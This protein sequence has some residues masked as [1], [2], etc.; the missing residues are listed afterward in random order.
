MCFSCHQWFGGNPVDS[1]VWVEKELGEGVIIL[2]REKMN[3]RARVS[4]LEEKEI[5]IHYK[6]QYQMLL[7]GAVSFESWQ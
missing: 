1:G 3:S 2:L 4:K 7:D 5:A 6:K